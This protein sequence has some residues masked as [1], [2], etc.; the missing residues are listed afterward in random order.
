MAAIARR[1]FE[2]RL[3]GATY[4]QIARAGGGIRSTV[5]ATRAAEPT[6]CSP[7]RATG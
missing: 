5:K 1:E 4:E 3:S 6:A 2:L 7:A